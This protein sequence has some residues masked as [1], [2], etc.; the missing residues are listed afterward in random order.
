LTVSPR[1]CN[2]GGRIVEFLGHCVG[3]GMRSIPERRVEA[4]RSYRKPRIKKQLR[5]FLV[6][7]SFYRSYVD[8][9]AREMATLTPV[10]SKAAPN[11][12]AW[13]SEMDQAFSNICGMVSMSSE[14]VIPDPEDVLSLVT[15]ASGKG[16]GAVLQV[17][18]DGEWKAA[19]FY[20]RQTRGPERRYFASELEV[21]A[22]VEAIR[23]FSPYL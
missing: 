19:A 2:W 11:T 21:L 23:Q 8:M 7:V 22:A 1:K 10:T 13:T 12:V 15:D 4:I 18:R 9:L 17:Q 14:L 5:A 16:L 3:D 6:V 20:S